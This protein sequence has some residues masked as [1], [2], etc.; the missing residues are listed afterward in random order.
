MSKKLN[1]DAMS[2]DEIWQLHEEIIRVL[3]ARLTSEKRA[4]ESRLSQLSR[5]TGEGAPEVEVKKNTHGKRRKY[6]MVFPKYR[7]ANESL[8]GAGKKPRPSK[9]VTRLRNL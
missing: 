9:L 5:E 7:N 1:L 4:L 2:V 3:S 6:Q 8:V